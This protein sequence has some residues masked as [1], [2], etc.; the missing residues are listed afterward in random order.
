MS[1]RKEKDIKIVVNPTAKKKKNK[2]K[3]K[4]QPGPTLKA[5][6]VTVS[7]SETKH[8]STNL[9]SLIPRGGSAKA[10]Q[11]AK[12]MEALSLPLETERIKLG[13]GYYGAQPTG[14][15]KLFHRFKETFPAG[16][17]PIPVEVFCFRSFL[18]AAVY[19]Y[20]GANSYDYTAAEIY[21]RLARMEPVVLNPGPLR[22][23]TDG[24][25]G[26]YLWPGR[27]GLSD[28]HRGYWVDGG[29]TIHVDSLS[30][31][32]ASGIALI[33]K[34]QDGRE[35]VEVDRKFLVVG[36]PSNSFSI[37][38]PGY[39]SVSVMNLEPV[40]TGGVPPQ[41]LFS[42]S[43]RCS[44]VGMRFGHLALPDMEQN[45]AAVAKGRVNAVSVMITNTTALISRQGQVTGAQLPPG[46]DWRSYQTYESISG[47]QNSYND[48]AVE[49]IYGFL[50][51]ED[52]AD[53]TMI[54]EFTALAPGVSNGLAEMPDLQDAAFIIIPER[55]FIVAA[56][57]TE[58]QTGYTGTLTMGYQVEYVSTDQWRELT[59]S[60]IHSST[61]DMAINGIAHLPQ[62]HK[63]EWHIDELWNDIRSFASNV[64]QGVVKYAP[65][66]A[67]VASLL[68]GVL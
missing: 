22:S 63:N 40:S 46:T 33:L 47:L 36:T 1:T 42:M 55:A 62:W 37:T 43:V 65:I 7:T 54:S 12:I 28:P 66:A 5:G 6:P 39:Y 4:T 68:L 57:S 9:K 44:V 2:K 48:D 23:N 14:A 53:F 30:P 21:V 56:L 61:L 59:V 27:L 60:D 64:A 50:K 52:P 17:T 13:A 67:E 16:P 19:S 32:G 38:A 35:W 10:R 41:H 51:P 29:G 34:V 58:V 25:H 45:F 31:V 24:P 18:R 26:F 49:G 15:T 20:W 11:I 3:K 8:A